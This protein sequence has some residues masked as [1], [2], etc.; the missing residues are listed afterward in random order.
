MATFLSHL[1]SCSLLPFPQ[2][3]NTIFPLLFL[4]F[5]SLRKSSF[6]IEIANSHDYTSSLSGICTHVLCIPA[7]HIEEQTVILSKAIPSIWV[8]DSTTSHKHT[9]I[10]QQSLLLTLSLQ[11]FC[12]WPH[13]S[14]SSYHL[15]SLLLWHKF[16]QEVSKL[17]RF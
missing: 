14:L 11:L 8:P 16:S 15:I 2:T 1:S 4:V 9:E 6:R 5:Y 13:S 3:P 10:L 17:L 12:S 7:V